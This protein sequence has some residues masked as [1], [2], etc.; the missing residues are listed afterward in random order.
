MKLKKLLFCI[1]S[2]LI[3]LT[4]MNAQDITV[5]GTVI[6]FYTQKPLEYIPVYIKHT[7]TGCLTNYDGEFYLKE[8]SGAD[9]LVVEAIGYGKFIQKLKPGSNSTIKVVLK[10][11]NVQL[12][13]AVVKPK[14]ER[15][16]KKENPAIELIRNV[17][18]N[19]KHNRI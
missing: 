10:P 3:S 9:T 17:I 2:A 5:R 7:A 14:R 1:F 11:E 6:D 19:K 4:A 18:A 12:V 13:G 15:Y 8:S 16:V